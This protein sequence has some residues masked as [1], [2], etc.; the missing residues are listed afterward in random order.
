LGES[1]RAK[2]PLLTRKVNGHFE[3]ISGARRYR[4]AERAG[5]REVP[6]RVVALTDEEALETQI[7][8]LSI[9]RKSFL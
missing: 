8:E 9:A 5:L 4:A 1:I 3:I 7:I 6:I 2:G